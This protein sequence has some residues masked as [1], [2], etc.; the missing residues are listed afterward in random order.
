[1]CTVAWGDSD[2]GLWVCFNRDEQRTR[3]P[4]EAPRLHSGP[5]GPVAYAR[6]PDGGGTWLA[7]A[8]GFAVGLLNAYP[9]D[10]GSASRGRKSRGLLV[11][12][13]AQ[14]ATAMEAFNKLADEDLGPYA[15]FYLLLCK[16]DSVTG[17]AWDGSALA[18]PRVEDGFWTTSSVDPGPV[19]A[20]RH[21]WWMRQ[22][23]G[24]CNDAERAGALLRQTCPDRPAYGTTMDR[25]DA[26][27]VSQTLLKLK[28][29]GFAFTYRPREAD[30]AGFEAPLTV[31]FPS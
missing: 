15:P 12:E 17:F 20:W 6:D 3:S 28:P 19:A 8:A 18:F 4:A 13:L 2:D 23:G 10:P 26:R 16:P 31:R 29:A 30:G 21:D 11:C 27:T 1:M 5:N 7:A 24:A 14:C 25:A 9:A 22:A